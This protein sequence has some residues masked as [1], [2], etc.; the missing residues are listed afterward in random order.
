M[1]DH[2][3]ERRLLGEEVLHV[4]ENDHRAVLRQLTSAG[5]EDN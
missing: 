2:A 1:P 4:F 5:A 3:L